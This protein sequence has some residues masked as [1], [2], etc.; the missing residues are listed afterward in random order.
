VKDSLSR[1]KK[2]MEIT[3]VGGKRIQFFT[4]AIMYN[5]ERKA[6]LSNGRT[7][8]LYSPNIEALLIV[9]AL[10]GRRHRWIVMVG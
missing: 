5:H 8:M 3:A 7:C 1:K 9:E 2:V 4:M 10:R 6:V